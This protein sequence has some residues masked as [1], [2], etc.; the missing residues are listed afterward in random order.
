MNEVAAAAQPAKPTADDPA[1]KI[2]DA[3]NAIRDQIRNSP[4][5]NGDLGIKAIKGIEVRGHRSTITVPAGAFPMMNP[6]PFERVFE[7]WHD[8]TPRLNSLMVLQV[9]DDPEVHYTKELESITL[10][11][12]DPALF[13]PPADYEI[14]EKEPPA[15]PAL[16]VDETK[17][18]AGR[19]APQQ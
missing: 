5:M 4:P 7:E 18:N 14:V 6:E 12:P 11:E 10:G 8:T 3:F 19:P 13:Q 9:I 2:H 17:P 15:C 1:T 16:R